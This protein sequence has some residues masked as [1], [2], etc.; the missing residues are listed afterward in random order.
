M[1]SSFP[2]S[3]LKLESLEFFD[4]LQQQQQERH[5]M[6]I[7]TGSS[8]S[9]KAS[10]MSPNFDGSAAALQPIPKK[11][12]II[13]T[14]RPRPHICTTCTRA[15]A[16]LEHLKRHERSHTNEKPF[17]CGACGRCFARRD[18]VLRHQQKL[19]ASLPTTNRTRT[20][21]HNFDHDVQAG[22][23]VQDYLN[24]NINIVYKNTNAKLPL[25]NDYK[26]ELREEEEDEEVIDSKLKPDSKRH[27]KSVSSKKSSSNQSPLFDNGT[28]PYNMSTSSSLDVSPQVIGSIYPSLQPH[29]S[30]SIPLKSEQ[31]SP[32]TSKPSPPEK[33]SHYNDNISSNIFQS[34]TPLSFSSQLMYPSNSDQIPSQKKSEEDLPHKRNRHSSFSA[35]SLSS[36]TLLKDAKDIQKH[37]I[38][39]APHQI[40]FATPQLSAQDMADRAL[41]A[42]FDLDALGIDTTEY[43][44][45]A[46]EGGENNEKGFKKQQDGYFT[47]N[48]VNN[49]GNTP[50]EF[51]ITPGGSLLDIPLLQQYLHVGG[52]GGG[53]G[54]ESSDFKLPPSSDQINKMDKQNS[55]EKYDWLAEFV[56][57]PFDI[58]FPPA[59]HHI[60][61]TDSPPSRDSPFTGTTPDDI[62]SLFRSRQIDLFKQISMNNDSSKSPSRQANKEGNFFSVEMR[63]QILTTY[64]L[65][66][67]Q[68]PLLEDLNKYMSL[69]EL[70]FDKYFPFIHFPSLYANHGEN[71][72][73]LML[74]M[75]AIGAL[76]SFHATNSSILAKL[77]RYLIHNFMGSLKSFDQFNDVPLPI[78]QGL[79]LDIYLGMFSNDLDISQITSKH[80][81]SVICLVK[82]T[83]LNVALEKFILPPPIIDSYTNDDPNQLKNNYEYFVLAQS[84]IRTVHVLYYL[85]VL[86]ASLV[87]NDIEL[88]AEDLQ[89][90]TPCHLEE[91]W[92][93]NNAQDWSSV[94]KANRIS[95]DSKFSLIQISNGE[96]MREITNELE[97]HYSDKTLNFKTL[98]SAL[99]SISETLYKRRTELQKEPNAALRATKW[100]MN[101]RPE[102]ESLLK[103]WEFIYVKNG[104]IL[105][106]REANVHV[107]NQT[108][109]LK[110]I[111]PLLSFA[112]LRK[113]IYFTPILSNI[114][115]KNWA[116]MNQ[117]LKYLD[118][119]PE[120]LRDGSNY[121]LDIINLWTDI[122][123]ISKDA[124]KT[125]IRTPI[126][127]LTCIFAAILVVG[128][129]LY[130]TEVW[131]KNYLAIHSQNSSTTSSPANA[132]SSFQN[133]TPTLNAID[134]VLWLKTQNLMKKVETNLNPNIPDSNNF[135]NVN[136]EVSSLVLEPSIDL[137]HTAEIIVMSKMSLKS[138]N[139]GVRILADAPVWPVALV[140]AEALKARSKFI[141][142]EQRT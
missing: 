65:K 7:T 56:S 9:T 26:M 74:A 69:Y 99:M 104:G 34:T 142:D 81:H 42:G 76:Y 114:W 109:V 117:E 6:N 120:A 10:S 140:F 75:A 108:P 87:G 110:L 78:T 44:D 97:N 128:E 63:N 59:S 28:T 1:S 84:R 93:A 70:E 68:F 86:F 123:M 17:Q 2:V 118:A 61:F 82:S 58:N 113:C 130:A 67:N 25:P 51:S 77:S 96:S 43:G 102:I 22:D 64:H 62:P 37:D 133:Q 90:G 36:Y 85:S 52:A 141:I 107:I 139:I 94:L 31:L 13:K 125:S 121:S 21:K 137:K 38:P 5:D 88:G 135:N 112:K 106:P 129:Y 41:M 124:E 98:L 100:R 136:D 115:S 71:H 15:F 122:I 132:F 49:K 105:V 89:S 57:T 126:F 19:H 16:R 48:T 18:L 45:M 4:N 40:G 32:V 111:L 47:N 80:L 55:E 79:V 27:R 35:A 92:K 72:L 138:L 127:F 46:N 29:S 50:F 12:A 83:Q 134:R 8:S 54:F 14:D 53:A 39:E 66:N 20:R 101:S 23:I 95:I 30:T 116:S 24:E 131:A 119:D 33:V 60:G 11:S 103:S 73:P 91:L 3:K